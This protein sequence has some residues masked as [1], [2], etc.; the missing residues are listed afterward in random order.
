[1]KKKYF[2]RLNLCATALLLYAMDKEK[3]HLN[4]NMSVINIILL[5]LLHDG[6]LWCSADIY[7]PTH[8]Q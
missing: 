5:L 8:V 1:M 6:G 3:L 2:Q 4:R 7:T